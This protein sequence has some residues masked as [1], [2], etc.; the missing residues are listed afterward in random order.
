MNSMFLH[1]EWKPPARSFP[2]LGSICNTNTVEKFKEIDK[3]ELL[4][5]LGHEV[6]LLLL[7]LLENSKT[8]KLLDKP[9]FYNHN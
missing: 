7:E 3:K 5:G 4:L 2:I 1:S 9:V 8:L 6:R